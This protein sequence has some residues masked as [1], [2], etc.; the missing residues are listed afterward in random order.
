MMR[1]PAN[2]SPPGR[3][4]RP[5]AHPDGPPPTAA[6]AEPHPPPLTG[7]TAHALRW[8]ALSAAGE[9]LL[10]LAFLAVLARLLTPRDFGVVAIALIFVGV[11]GVAGRLG[12]GPAIVQRPG[13]TERHVATGF[14]L[15]AALGAALSAAVWF[16]SP[17]IARFFADPEAPAILGALSA[18]FVIT[19]LGEV[20]EH[21]LRRRLRFG[22]LMLA[23]LLSQAAGYGPVAIALALHGFG[24]WS[25]VGGLLARHALFTA[26]VVACRPPPL[27]PALS[28]HAAAELLR[29]GTGFSVSALMA[30]IAGRGARFAIASGLGA[31]ALGHYAQAWRVAGAPNRLG[32]VLQ[33]VLFPAM[34]ERQ[35]RIDRLRPVY[36]H[37]MEITS[38]LAV[39]ASV[40]MVL[41]A[42]EII[43]VL[44]G[45]QWDAAVPVLQIL[46]AGTAFHACN[47]INIPA[48]R[49]LGAVWREACSRAL[50]ALLMVFGV[51]LGVRWGLAG[52]AAAIVAA[53]ILLHLLL[54]QLALNLLG[55]P[56]RRLLRCHAPALWAAAWAAAA[57]WVA[58]GLADRAAFPAAA[59]LAIGLAAWTA[60]AAAAVWTAPAFARPRSVPWLLVRLPFAELG[61]AG[62]L[63]RLMLERLDPGPASRNS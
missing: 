21:L 32:D 54:T 39:T 5:C 6:A 20:S 31:A 2:P 23:T 25:L 10:S 9:A 60:A 14:A 27:R 57:L 58:T 22:Q 50:F 17:A 8:S 61:T 62:R 29:F 59:T 13:L 16:A 1:R 34:A 45:P 49:A 7:R 55:L 47:V 28:R 52:A 42:P 12:I 44:F 15:S 46:A 19:G 4:R 53:R 36:L 40:P 38:L 43:A 18:V 51:W 26:V 30:A 33:R 63:L 3:E 41:C 48:I 37:G 24:A 56:W 35:E 11:V